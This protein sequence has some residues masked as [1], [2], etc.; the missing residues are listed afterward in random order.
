VNQLRRTPQFGLQ[1]IA[2]GDCH[3][4]ILRG[5][6]DLAAADYLEAVI[7]CLFV[8]GIDEVTLN[9]S[10]L[11]FIDAAGLRALL[12]VQAL[13]EVKGC[14]FSLT[15]PVGQVR[16]LFELTGVMRTLPI[17]ARDRAPKSGGSLVWSI[18]GPWPAGRQP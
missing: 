3:T 4:L 8:D 13:C 17:D 7:F 2:R 14:R 9:L 10:R 12:A 16:R 15:R 11:M 18:C 6:L 1:D 5:E